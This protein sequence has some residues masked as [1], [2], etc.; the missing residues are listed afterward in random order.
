MTNNYGNRCMQNLFVFLSIVK[1]FQRIT[2]C[3]TA[4]K[5]CIFLESVHTNIQIIHFV[6]SAILK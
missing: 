2:F 4:K 3:G 5:K 6:Y 1:E